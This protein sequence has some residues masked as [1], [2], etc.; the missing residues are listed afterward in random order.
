MYETI[1]SPVRMGN[2]ELKNRIVF[3]P[4]SMGLG[5]AEYQEMIR[6][7]A[8]GGCGMIIIGDV[9]V[10]RRAFFGK[11]LYSRKGFAFYQELCR[12]AHR[13]DCRICAQLHQSDSNIRGMLKYI[14]GVLTK[15][16][17]QDQLR[18]LLNEQV[19]ALINGM[20]EKK[21]SAVTA[22]FGEAAKQAVSAGFDM[23]QI[24]GDRMTGSFSSSLFNHR[25]DRYGGTARNRA[26]FGEEAV[27]A[28]RKA[29]PDIPIDYKLAVRQ[30]NPDYGKAGVLLDELAVFVP[31]LEQAGVT[32][33]HVALANHSRLTDTIPPAS[34]P[35]FGGQGCFLPFCDAVR[36][37]T[38][39]PV[40]G[41]GG[42]TDPDFVEEQLKKGR[43]DCAAM[44]RQL[45]A[46][47]KWPVRLK[48]GKKET[49][50]R[51]IRCNRECLGGIQ[52]HRGVHCIYE[53]KE[54]Q[55]VGKG[56][57]G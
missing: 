43:I 21:V 36:S 1:F 11:T 53:K 16:I 55:R 23:I 30:E 20:P 28:V 44:S 47:P 5:D 27:R 51:C 24:H 12:T 19:E 56:E 34:H 31:A 25:T 41:V 37:F 29:L 40:T 18:V 52:A 54:K 13:Y 3:A 9:P 45:I 17:T 14:P 38:H 49:I 39:L 46:D 33:F 48:A 26:R 6:K 8:S 7:I 22:S 4:T 42:L 57:R 32:S 15:K 35:D 50:H 10:S 2:V